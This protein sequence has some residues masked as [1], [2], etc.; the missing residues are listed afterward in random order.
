MQ[1]P[2]YQKQQM[3][4]LFLICLLIMIQGCSN[5]PAL[6]DEQAL[7]KL[8]SKYNQIPEN[9]RHRN[10]NDILAISPK[11]WKKNLE[12]E[13]REGKMRQTQDSLIQT[14]LEE[15]FFDQKLNAFTNAFH[16]PSID[17]FFLQL[18]NWGSLSL[19]SE[20]YHLESNKII[21]KKVLRDPDCNYLT[22]PKTITKECFTVLVKKE[23]RISKEQWNGIKNFI[24]K[25]GFWGFPTRFHSSCMDG[26]YVS[27]FLRE[28]DRIKHVAVSCP[29]AQHS[30]QQLLNQIIQLL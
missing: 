15:P 30:I 27:V 7:Q 12:A 9:Y 1:Y 4:R 21:Y 22:G 8:I 10:L 19:I 18:G 25:C 13:I 11:S 2:F 3:Q 26:N 29:P 23:K 24:Q 28:N 17:T 5:S 6:S 20:I 16:N 14:A